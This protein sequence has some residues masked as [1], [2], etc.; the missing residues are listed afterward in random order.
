MI[1]CSEHVRVIYGVRRGLINS[2][3]LL[4][5]WW[6]GHVRTWYLDG[7]FN[8]L[9]TELFWKKIKIKEVRPLY[10][11][12]PF[13]QKTNI[14]H[15]LVCLWISVKL[16]SLKITLRILSLKLHPFCIGP[17]VLMIKEIL[18][19]YTWLWSQHYAYVMS[20]CRHSDDLIFLIHNHFP[21]VGSSTNNIY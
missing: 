6:R 5:T 7:I 17:N 4:A 14:K 19:K 21:L 10:N 3:M 11:M 20:I 8:H 1:Q 12:I 15:S 2:L 16:F 9:C 18:K 13:L